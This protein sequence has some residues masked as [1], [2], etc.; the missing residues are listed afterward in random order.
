M[1]G[2]IRPEIHVRDYGAALWKRKWLALLAFAAV[3]VPV[4]VYIAFIQVP[5]YQSSTTMMVKVQGKQ[6]QLFAAARPVTPVDVDTEIEI[7]KSPPVLARPASILDT[8]GLQPKKWLDKIEW[9]RIEQTPV[10]HI[11]VEAT[12]PVLARDIA[13]ALGES[14]IDYS[15][16]TMLDSSRTATV[17]LERQLADAQ[18]RLRH[19][20]QRMQ[21]FCKAH[22]EA[23]FGASAEMGAAVHQAL[24]QEYI[25]VEYQYASA[26]AQFEEFGNLMMECGI[27]EPGSPV[28][29]PARLVLDDNV[30]PEKLSMLAALSA[31]ERLAMIS[32]EL[33]RSRAALSEKQKT[34]KPQH[35]MAVELASLV[36]THEN[37][38]QTA[39]VTECHKGYMRR[40][41]MLAGLETMLKQKKQELLDFR[42]QFYGASSESMEFAVLDRNANASQMLY[43]TVLEKL[44]EFDLSEGATSE[45]ARFIQPAMLGVLKNPQNGIKLAFA[46]LCGTLLAVGVA[47]LLEYFDTTL[48]SAD[49]IERDLRLTVIGTLPQT[50][51]QLRPPESE[52]SDLLVVL[53]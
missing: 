37:H 13:T 29:A 35:P 44:K 19:D 39:F 8:A 38:Y 2:A 24:M 36:A 4:V 43:N 25:E 30:A 48:K 50:R 15:R 10:V 28:E 11:T 49:D 1:E 20:Q 14:Y 52:E 27:P 40:R 5:T 32:A 34:L 21:D 18:A 3:V 53:D 17:W 46:L 45:S 7:M 6:A 26:K 16:R 47:L 22:P 33:D 31:S 51:G 23:N 9:L 12:T 42:K 41:G